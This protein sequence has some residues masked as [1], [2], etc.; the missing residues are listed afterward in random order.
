M[1]QTSTLLGNSLATYSSG[2][3]LCSYTNVTHR[4]QIIRIKNIPDLQ[5]DKVIF[6]GQCLMFEAVPEANLEVQYTDN[7]SI[8]VPCDQLHVSEKIQVNQSGN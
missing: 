7:M 1:I 6:P 3:I 4:I 2:R 8:F 5:L